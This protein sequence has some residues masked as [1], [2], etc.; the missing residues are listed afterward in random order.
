M[1]GV[2]SVKR[3]LAVILVVTFFL[4]NVAGQQVVSLRLNIVSQFTRSA[5]SCIGG[6]VGLTD[7]SVA[8]QYRLIPPQNPP[9][10][11]WRTVSEIDTSVGFDGTLSFTTDGSSEDSVQFRLLQLQHGGGDCNCWTVLEA[12]AAINGGQNDTLSMCVRASSR[13]NIY[14]FCGGIASKAR[15]FISDVQNIGNKTD[16]CPDNSSMPSFLNKGPSLP[17]HCPITSA[18]YV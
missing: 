1:A 15:G 13:S 16:E 2:G 4:E 10:S 5:A 6:D 9:V 14:M 11:E 18:M 3:S 17:L 7:F 12:S 8:V